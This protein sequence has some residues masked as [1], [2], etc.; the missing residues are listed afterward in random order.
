M[1][2]KSKSQKYGIKRKS[3]TR[4]CRL[5]LKYINKYFLNTSIL[6]VFV[7]NRNISYFLIAKYINNPLEMVDVVVLGWNIRGIRI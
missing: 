7:V 2:N 6:S 5:M 1:R 4:G 3:K